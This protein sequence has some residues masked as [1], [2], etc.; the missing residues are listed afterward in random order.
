MDFSGT[1]VFSVKKADNSVNVTAAG[2]ISCRTHHKSLSRRQ[3]QTVGD[4]Y[5]MLYKTMGHLMA[6][7]HA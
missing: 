4:L 6:T 2:I 7:S 3:E 1:Q 5:V